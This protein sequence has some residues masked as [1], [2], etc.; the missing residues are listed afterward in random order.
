MHF[1]A[2][3]YVRKMDLPIKKKYEWL[4]DGLA[5]FRHEIQA[6]AY[7]NAAN[8]AEETIRVTIFNL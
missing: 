1:C 2:K 4:W 5:L 6:V 3:P 8:S 7:D